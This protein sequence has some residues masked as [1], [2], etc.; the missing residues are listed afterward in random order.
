MTIINSLHEL[1]GQDL[2]KEKMIRFHIFVLVFFYFK[3]TFKN[4]NSLIVIIL[5]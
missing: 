4:N 2:F 5:Q 1:A 3:V